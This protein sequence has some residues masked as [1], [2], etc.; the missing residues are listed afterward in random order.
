[1]NSGFI[2]C[3]YNKQHKIQRKDIYNHFHFRCKAAQNSGKRYKSCLFDNS[4][5]F[6]DGDE[7]RLH[8]DNCARCRESYENFNDMSMISKKGNKKE[9]PAFSENSRLF[10]NDLNAT[11]IDK[12]VNDSQISEELK[13]NEF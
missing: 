7:S 12:S 13:N 2:D 5:F 4:I 10:D 8:R 1:M 9:V 11:K 3:P 6:L